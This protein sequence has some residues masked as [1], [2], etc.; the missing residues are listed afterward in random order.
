MTN[1]EVGRRLLVEFPD[2]N[3]SRPVAVACA[4]SV[5]REMENQPDRLSVN[6][7][8]RVLIDLCAIDLFI[9]EPDEK[10]SEDGARTSIAVISV[11]METSSRDVLGWAIGQWPGFD[12]Q[13]A[14]LDEAMITLGHEDIHGTDE[15]C[16]EVEVNFVP[17]IDRKTESTERTPLSDSPLVSVPMIGP[18][19]FGRQMTSL[20]GARIGKLGLRPGST[21]PSADRTLLRWSPVVRTWEDAEAVVS[22]AI[23][24]HK[25]EVDDRLCMID[26][27]LR[28]SR[29]GAM[30]RKLA[31]I[32][33]LAE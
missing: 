23:Q 10:K 31:A 1:G 5:R 30:R 17:G 12:L 16:D 18:R 32:R 19:R 4:Q 24:R 26:E 15:S 21:A 33:A 7:G 14:A 9:E 22:A 11:V 2:L 8:K 28:S 6:F 20:L 13:L 3:V 29:M 25:T 27:Q